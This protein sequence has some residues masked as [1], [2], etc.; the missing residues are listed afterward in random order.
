MAHKA[1]VNPEEDRAL[2][3]RLR[4]LS[5]MFLIFPVIILFRVLFLNVIT[6]EELAAL[7]DR[8]IHR[9]VP[10]DAP[11]GVIYDRN[12]EALATN[13]LL[14]NVVGQPYRMR[15]DVMTQSLDMVERITQKSLTAGERDRMLTRAVYANPVPIPSLR[16]LNAP[17]AA[18]ILERLSHLPGLSY[19]TVYR[20]YY[21]HG[22]LVSHL[23]GFVNEYHPDFVARVD[24][25]IPGEFGT[26]SEGD[27]M[28]MLNLEL[29]CENYLRGSKGQRMVRQ[30]RYHRILESFAPAPKSRPGQD[31][32]LTID[33]RLQRRADAL[34]AEVPP[35]TPQTATAR[36]QANDGETPAKKTPGLVLAMNPQTGA[37]LAMA[38]YPNFDPHRSTAPLG[39][40]EPSSQVN[41]ALAGRYMPGS[42]FKLVTA[43][44]ILKNGFDANREITCGKYYYLP[45]WRRPFGCTGYHGPVNLSDALQRSCNVYF[46]TMAFEYLGAERF[47]E[48]AFALGFGQPTGIDSTIS[49]RNWPLPSPSEIV[50]GEL[51][52]AS[53]GQGKIITTPIQVLR[54]YA[55]VANGGYL[56]RPYVVE[57]IGDQVV[58]G[59][60]HE[61]RA[62]SVT[63]GM[64][65][66]QADY[67][68]HAL[69]R[70]VN[71]QRGTAFRQ[72]YP[73]EWNAAGKT[74]SVQVVGQENTTAWFVGFAPEEKPVISVLIILEN[75]GLG[76]AFAAPLGKAFL[77]EYFKYYTL[78]GRPIDERAPW[79]EDPLIAEIAD[80]PIT[81]IESSVL[82]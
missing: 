31:I 38:S 72:N 27:W 63:T 36:R 76:G 12:G 48:A 14:F 2:R 9:M 54:A 28:G 59:L 19:E 44:A 51:L 41:K 68:K 62:T 55:A 1:P 32:T 61:D 20:R 11:R 45:Q 18:P 10:I 79:S 56:V 21:P 43:Y 26:F 82:P 33:L 47:M 74:S 66:A 57:K 30:D 8:N 25:R 34:L 40:D 77:E 7:S 65:R 37:I 70:V 53:I 22:P 15:R 35:S 23:L 58:G 73:R 71:E 52:N 78:D 17:R 67:L 60:F 49:E 69:W 16:N 13:Q 80:R 46:Y 3:Q 39:P 64:T 5:A 24:G 50:R 4:H 6:G 42:T 29:I 75:V 81:R